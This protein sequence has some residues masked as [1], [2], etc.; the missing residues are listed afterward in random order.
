MSTSIVKIKFLRNGKKEGYLAKD[1]DDWGWLRPWEV[2]YLEMNDDNEEEIRFKIPDW[3]NHM[4]VQDSDGAIGFW[5]GGGD[6]K[7]DS[8]R[9]YEGHLVSNR[10]NQKLSCWGGNNYLFCNDGYRAL[11]VEL[12]YLK[13]GK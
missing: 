5:S 7:K 13:E 12:H 6:F 1:K 11:D 10:N 8:F 3:D 4:T 9:W 2:A